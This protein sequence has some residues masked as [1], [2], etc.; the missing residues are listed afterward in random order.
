MIGTERMPQLS[1]GSLVHSNVPA[2]QGLRLRSMVSGF[3]RK[4]SITKVMTPAAKTKAPIVE[5]MLNR[6]Q[7]T[8][9]GY[10][11]T[12]R[13]M[14]R[15]PEKCIGKKPTL[16]PTNISQKAVLP[17]VAESFFPVTKGK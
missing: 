12:R 6:S 13:G 17:Q 16:K 2:F 10:V 8:S 11:K 5:I 9:S 14:P 15:N 1:L 7:P 4:I 3:G